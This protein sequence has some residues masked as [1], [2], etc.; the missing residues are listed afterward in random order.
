MDPVLARVAVSGRRLGWEAVRRRHNVAADAA[1]TAGCTEAARRAAMGDLR[2]VSGS[3]VLTSDSTFCF[4]DS[5]AYE[6]LWQDGFVIY[7]A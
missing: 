6:R 7:G 5:A 1:A 3:S 4:G 2:E